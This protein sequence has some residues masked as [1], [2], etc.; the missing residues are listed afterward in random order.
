[1]VPVTAH[2]FIS[3]PREEIFDFVAD[4]ANRA[5]WTDHFTAELRLENPRSYGVG[6]AARYQLRGPFYKPWIE[7]EVIEADRPR[8]L[9]EATR[10]GRG[11][12]TRGEITIELSRQGQGLTRVEMTIASEPGT[13]REA[14]MERLRAR[15][16]LRR[17]AKSALERLRTL[18]EERPDQPLVRTGVAGWEADKAPRF[19]L[20]P[21]S[22]PGA[23]SG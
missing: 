20:L 21:G 19:G 15:P 6:A 4:L 18:F 22:E 9:V 2:T 7:T 13:P 16:W 23:A 1:M 5:A 14:V 3:A 12:R 8:R 10:G 17:Q 11:G